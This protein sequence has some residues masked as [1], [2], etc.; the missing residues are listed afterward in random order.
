[1]WTKIRGS[2]SFFLF[3][4]DICE[5]CTSINKSK[6]DIGTICLDTLSESMN[7]FTFIRHNYTVKN[8]SFTNSRNH[9]F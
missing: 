1:M 2:F 5:R 4:C 8:Y 7:N 6:L 9:I 3:I